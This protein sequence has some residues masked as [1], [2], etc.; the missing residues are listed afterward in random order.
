MA[1]VASN[2]C[3]TALVYRLISVSVLCPV[4]VAIWWV[5][6]P[7]SASRLPETA[8]RVRGRVEAVLAWATVSGYRSGDNPARW[9]GHLEQA[10]PARAKLARVEHHA[11]LPYHDMAQFWSRL[12]GVTGQGAM[13]L[14]FAILTAARSGEVR[15]M[16]W[17]R[18]TWSGGSGRSQRSV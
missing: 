3:S 15:G 1:A 12:G 11:A 8:G 17:A 18:S 7:A 9:C 16:T 5:E 6:H 14:R 2:F 13:A 10:L 4:M